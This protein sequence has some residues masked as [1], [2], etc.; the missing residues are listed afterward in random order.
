MSNKPRLDAAR[1]QWEYQRKMAH[2]MDYLQFDMKRLVNLLLTEHWKHH[3]QIIPDWMPNFPKS[4]TQPKCVVRYYNP[5]NETQQFLRHSRG[6][7]QGYFWDVY[8]DDFDDLTLALVALSQASAPS[9]VS[10]TATHG[11]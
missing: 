1:E 10:V 8:G 5:E 3:C 2:R 11:Q 9:N 6:P 7:L 4:D